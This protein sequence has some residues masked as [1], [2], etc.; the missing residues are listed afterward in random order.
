[1]KLEVGM[2]VRT[3]DGEIFKTDN[4]L[5]RLSNDKSIFY[6]ILTKIPRESISYRVSKASHNLIDLI[7]VGDIV[8]VFS[9]LHDSRGN[10]TFNIRDN[11]HLKYLKIG[12]DNGCFHLINIA[13]KEQ[14][15]SVSYRVGD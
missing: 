7:E 12:F 5:L 15:E 6:R 3:E 14:F 13:T 11:N 2:Y 10:E 1:M 8:T 9:N 4:D